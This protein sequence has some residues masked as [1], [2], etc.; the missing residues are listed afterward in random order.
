MKQVL[1]KSATIN[2][3]LRANKVGVFNCACAVEVTADNDEIVSLEFPQLNRET[4]G[5]GVSVYMCMD[6]TNLIVNLC[7]RE[8]IQ[9]GFRWCETTNKW[10]ETDRGTP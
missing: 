6:G 4:D 1:H 3:T 10:V 5:Q 2:A 9:L 7:D 8:G